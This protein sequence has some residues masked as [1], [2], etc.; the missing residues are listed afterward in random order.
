VIDQGPTRGDQASPGSEDR[1]RLGG[2]LA[3]YA[4]AR[5]YGESQGFARGRRAGIDL[6]VRDMAVGL[7]HRLNVGRFG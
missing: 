6:R 3:S 2:G 1:R 5:A 7:Q 4:F